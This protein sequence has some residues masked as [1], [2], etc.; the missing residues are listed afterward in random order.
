MLP[1]LGKWQPASH[2][3]YGF[4]SMALCNICSH[5]DFDGLHY[6]IGITIYNQSIQLYRQLAGKLLSLVLQ[7]A[8]YSHY[9][10]WIC[11]NVAKWKTMQCVYLVIKKNLNIEA[12]QSYVNIYTHPTLQLTS[13]CSNLNSH[14][15]ICSYSY[16]LYSIILASQLATQLHSIA[17]T[18]VASQLKSL[19]N[20]F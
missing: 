15:Y 10:R 11:M 9:K 1:S 14:S 6:A 19:H 17:N 13:Y 7:L 20:S 5:R 4:Y 2:G 12:V 18:C 3:I 8:R 16:T